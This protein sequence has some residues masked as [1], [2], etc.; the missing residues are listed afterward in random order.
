MRTLG[1]GVL[2]FLEVILML[3]H[4]QVRLVQ[5]QAAWYHRVCTCAQE[6]L[7]Q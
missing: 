1:A 3:L 4:Q 6:A 5:P 7:A 2:R